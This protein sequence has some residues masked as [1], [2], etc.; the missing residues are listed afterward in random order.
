MND[1]LNNWV[2]SSSAPRN[3]SERVRKLTLLNIANGTIEPFQKR[4]VGAGE[5]IQRFAH[6]PTTAVDVIRNGIFDHIENRG[7]Y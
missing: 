6:V 5:P 1:L 2:P 3:V 7:A 4:T